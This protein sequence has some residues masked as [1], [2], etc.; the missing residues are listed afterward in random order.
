M[1]HGNCG[2]VCRGSVDD[3]DPMMTRAEF[4]SLVKRDGLC[5]YHIMCMAHQ[6]HVTYSLDGIAKDT[7]NADVIDAAYDYCVGALASPVHSQAPT[8][9]RAPVDVSTFIPWEWDTSPCPILTRL[10]SSGKDADRI[11]IVTI[12]RACMVT[13][14]LSSRFKDV[15]VLLLVD[16]CS[17]EKARLRASSVVRLFERSCNKN[18]SIPRLSH[19]FQCQCIIHARCTL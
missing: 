18:Y 19:L 17:P 5:P 13:I 8:I 2:H 12:L 15:M 4:V 14:L 11:D 1:A 7:V 6:A 3:F 10:M 9:Y 16:H